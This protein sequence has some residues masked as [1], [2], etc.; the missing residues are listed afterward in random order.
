MCVCPS[1]HAALSRCRPP[2]VALC[3]I[4]LLEDSVTEQEEGG[5]A[6]LARLHASA[7]ERATIHKR[8]LEVWEKRA[9]TLLDAGPAAKLDIVIMHGN[10][11]L[12]DQF[13][14]VMQEQ[15]DNC[16]KEEATLRAWNARS[17]GRT[18]DTMAGQLGLLRKQLDDVTRSREMLSEG[19]HTAEVEGALSKVDE[20]GRAIRQ[21][22]SQLGDER[23]LAAQRE[24]A[25]AGAAAEHRQAVSSA[26]EELKAA[27][28][29][30]DSGLGRVVTL[31]TEAVVSMQKHEAFRARTAKLLVLQSHRPTLAKCYM[32]WRSLTAQ[33][34]GLRLAEG[35][36]ANAIAELK[37]RSLSAAIGGASG[38][39]GSLASEYLK[40]TL[41]AL[42]DEWATREAT[43]D[44]R[45]EEVSEELR[46][47]KALARQAMRESEEQRAR[48]D[49]QAAALAS[50][51]EALRQSNE[52]AREGERKAQYDLRIMR[53][54][55]E[56]ASSGGQIDAVR[57]G[58]EKAA[59]DRTVDELRAQIRAANEAHA[60]EVS[61]L[62][63]AVTDSELQ[64]IRLHEASH[65]ASK[66]LAE[67]KSEAAD[68]TAIAISAAQ[69][70]AVRQ[71]ETLEV[72]KKSL[73]K[74]L[75]SES[76]KLKEQANAS[77]KRM[78]ELEASLERATDLQKRTGARLHEAEIER[79]EL[80]A[81][82]R[83]LG[84]SP[85]AR[86]SPDRPLETGGVA[87][88]SPVEGGGSVGDGGTSGDAAPKDAARAFSSK[89][90]R[91]SG[92]SSGT[93]SQVEGGGV[94]GD[95]ASGDAAPKDAAKA[96]SSKSRRTSRG[97]SGTTRQSDGATRSPTPHRQNGHQSGHHGHEH[98]K[99]STSR[100]RT[101]RASGEMREPSQVG[102]VGAE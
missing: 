7:A 79:E 78:A 27:A 42:E 52:L 85:A 25:A 76:A 30:M 43:A 16:A 49:R 11:D 13:R 50:E 40:A 102:P 91:R 21:L 77:A 3:Q 31:E 1:E 18:R 63:K 28:S 99:R 57:V 45:M 34:V 97:S 56:K 4:A 24:R 39:G 75:E 8:Q 22:E 67:A 33:T 71:V 38:A 89:S 65:A 72:D 96:F 84:G 9:A 73:N 87:V 10:A 61:S 23:R 66:A 58:L 55:V 69:I 86:R 17:D 94:S 46:A 15:R 90:R 19:L 51:G 93:K 54:R 60:A 70:E 35:G 82:L 29:E 2:R 41:N 95:V 74:Q 62:R 14:A 26:V 5:R 83:M 48:L 80:R 68:A 44:G 37:N 88:E 36:P 92:G 98:G 53:Q 6:L 12:F 64:R 101:K 47:A 20:A 59:A 81:G 100:P 32:A